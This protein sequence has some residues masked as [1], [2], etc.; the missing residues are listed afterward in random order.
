MV[1]VFISLELIYHMCYITV[2][3]KL[4]RFHFMF[5]LLLLGFKIIPFPLNCYMM[6]IRI[7]L[8]AQKQME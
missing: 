6:F 7:V 2:S 5:Q 1:L 8:L 3:L 4:F